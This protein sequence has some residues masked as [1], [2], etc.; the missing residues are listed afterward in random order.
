MTER[1]KLTEDRI[2]YNEDTGK[3]EITIREDSG[4]YRPGIWKKQLLYNDKKGEKWDILEN[5][6]TQEALVRYA[7][8]D[9]ENKQLKKDLELLLD[10]FQVNAN[11]YFN[12]KQ[13]L[14]EI[15]ELVESGYFDIAEYNG[16]LEYERKN[17]EKTT[18]LIQILNSVKL[19]K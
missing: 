18:K 17:H 1:I 5:A 13:R 12:L 19:M 10:K 14:D 2:Y 3:L 8:L 16:D 9:Q 6:S 15:K 11:K 4:L 7:E